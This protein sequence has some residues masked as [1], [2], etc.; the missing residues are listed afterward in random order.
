MA[1]EIQPD[2][3]QVLVQLERIDRISRLLGKPYD[4]KTIDLATEHV[5]MMVAFVKAYTRGVGF[6]NGEPTGELEE[7]IASATTRMMATPPGKRGET[8]GAFSVQYAPTVEGFTLLE[9][10]ILNRYR[11][12]A[13]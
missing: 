1:A 5:P 8:V 7:V 10:A 9:L 2:V 6:T 12:R 4:E 11:R 3:Q 13:A